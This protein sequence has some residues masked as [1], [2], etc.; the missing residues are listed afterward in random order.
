MNC[1]GQVKTTLQNYWLVALRPQIQ[2]YITC[3]NLSIYRRLL[4]VFCVIS[5]F[6][7]GLWRFS[8]TMPEWMNRSTL[9][10][11]ISKIRWF[12][13][14]ARIVNIF[15]ECSQCFKN[16]KTASFHFTTTLECLSIVSFMCKWTLHHLLLVF[17]Y[18]V[19][20]VHFLVILFNFLKNKCYGSS[21]VVPYGFC[22]YYVE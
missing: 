16:G 19:L 9:G 13:F 10:I 6:S 4:G 15:F 20:V 3:I 5:G 8:K 14:L 11:D 12:N 2:A 7:C 17:N 22:V 21:R 1:I 18:C